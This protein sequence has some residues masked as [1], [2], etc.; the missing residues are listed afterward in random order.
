MSTYSED[1][2]SKNQTVFVNII[3][4]YPVLLEKSN[5]PE[6]KN[7]RRKAA[8]EIK[9]KVE[10]E[11]GVKYNEGQICEKIQNIKTRLKAKTDRYQTGNKPIKLKGWEQ[12]LFNFLP[13]EPN[14]SIARLQCAVVAGCPQKSVDYTP[15]ACAEEET[16]TEEASGSSGPVLKATTMKAIPSKEPSKKKG[17]RGLV[18]TDE[19]RDL[20][21]TELQRLVLLEQVFRLAKELL[22]H[23]KNV[24]ESDP[25]LS[26]LNESAETGNPI[27]MSLFLGQN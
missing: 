18:E 9:E 24:N 4:Q 16:I 14:P 27:F 1:H 26:T 19:A 7:K 5:I 21:I 23:K 25:N 3:K 15:T 20:S 13:G 22:L 6:I 12:E 17:K 10:A 8:E 2:S 11:L